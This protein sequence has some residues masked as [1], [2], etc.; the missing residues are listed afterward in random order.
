VQQ[1]QQNMVFCVKISYGCGSLQN[2]SR[3]M[4]LCAI[5]SRHTRVCVPAATVAINVVLNLPRRRQQNRAFKPSFPFS[6][7]CLRRSTYCWKYLGGTSRWLSVLTSLM[8][9]CMLRPC[10]GGA[11][12][13]S[14]VV[15]SSQTCLDPFYC[16]IV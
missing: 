16:Y 5:S 1:L 3:H 7:S 12:V 14:H 10:N 4:V 8:R 6:P 2:I 11:T 15:S 13:S 9:T